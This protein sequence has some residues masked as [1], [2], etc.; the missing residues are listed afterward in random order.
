MSALF[1][2]KFL[3]Y[4]KGSF[5]SGELIFP[6]GISHLK[7]PRTFEVFRDSSIIKNGL[8][9]ANHLSMAPRV[10]QVIPGQIYPQDRYQQ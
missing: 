1:R 2:G 6:G 10:F 9:I 5:E 8:S 3:D 7:D 4:L